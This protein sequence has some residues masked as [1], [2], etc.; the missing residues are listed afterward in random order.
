M[1]IARIHYARALA[2][3]LIGAHAVAYAA[4]A[5]ET[6]TFAVWGG[7]PAE[8]AALDNV[9]AAF[10]Q[11]TGITVKKE[12]I[13]DKY[14]DVLKTRFAARNTPDVFYLDSHEAPLLIQSGVLEPMD[15]Y[16]DNQ[17]DFYPQFINALRGTDGKVYGIPKDY[18][19]DR[20]SVV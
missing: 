18:S 11:A 15:A 1:F 14:M 8:L 6:V 12:V 20:K 10:K 16:V 19:T 9:I 2:A 17:Q 5:A 7:L 4:P 3:L 13:A